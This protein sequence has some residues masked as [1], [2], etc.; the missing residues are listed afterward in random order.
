MTAPMSTP[1][2][3]PLLFPSR[4]DQTKVLPQVVRWSL[5]AP[6]EKQA[7]RN[8]DQTLARLAAR[9]GLS[10][11]ELVAVLEDRSWAPMRE[12]SASAALLRKIAEHEI[13]RDVPTSGFPSNPKAPAGDDQ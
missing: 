5:V 13:A 9:G 7:K 1:A 12:S 8:H 10:P 4:G 2:F 6:H 3:F 11:T